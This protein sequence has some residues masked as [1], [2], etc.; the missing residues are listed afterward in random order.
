MSDILQID[1]LLGE[2]PEDLWRLMKEADPD[3][4]AIRAYLSDSHILVARLGERLAGVAVL[5]KSAEICEL[6]NLAVA[7]E[8]RERGIAKSL[9]AKAKDLATELG[10]RELEVG[11]GNSSLSQLAL[12]Q[13]CG[14]RISHVDRDFFLSYPE[15]IWENGIQCRDM[16]ILRAPL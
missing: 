14:F 9:I 12:Y 5:R 15:P 11:T 7:S 2:A 1:P 10:A 13:K 3:E 8:F 16:V 6:K 4:A